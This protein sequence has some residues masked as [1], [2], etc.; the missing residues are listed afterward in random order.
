[1]SCFEWEH[2]TL[3]QKF[4]RYRLNIA[5]DIFKCISWTKMREFRLI[6]HWILFPMVQ[7]TLL[8]HWFRKWLG[9]EQAISHYLN[10][11]CLNHWLI[12]A[13]L[14][15]NEL[16]NTCLS[17]II[18]IIC[19]ISYCRLYLSSHFWLQN[20]YSSLV[21]VQGIYDILGSYGAKSIN[22]VD[23]LTW[24]YGEDSVFSE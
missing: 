12:Y 22:V 5:D 9:A 21:V 14:V 4:R 11:S 1:M 13:S 8:Q 20:I 17:Y 16:L 15:H 18:I 2:A 23:I 7:L 19:V 24:L 3:R 10:K 6:F